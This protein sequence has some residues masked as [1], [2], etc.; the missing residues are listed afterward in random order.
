MNNHVSD[1]EAKLIAE[2]CIQAIERGSGPADKLAQLYAK[3]VG[4][5][6]TAKADKW[7]GGP[8]QS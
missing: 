1:S 3:M 4:Q 5:P 8:L 6:V 2:L 7:H